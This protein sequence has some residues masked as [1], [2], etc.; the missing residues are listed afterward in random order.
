MTVKVIYKGGKGSG[1]YNHSGRPGEIGGSGPTAIHA[2]NFHKVPKYN[3]VEIDDESDNAMVVL[4]NTEG[5]I[6]YHDNGMQSMNWNKVPGGWMQYHPKLLHNGKY[7]L[8]KALNWPIE[9]ISDNIAAY[10]VRGI[11]TLDEAWS[12]LRAEKV[13]KGGAGS[14]HHGHAGRPGKRGG[15]APDKMTPISDYE[16]TGR[17]TKGGTALSAD[18]F[19]ALDKY[20]ES[21]A[22]ESYKKNVKSYI[23]D[24][25]VVSS[26]NAASHV[27]DVLMNDTA[28]DNPDS[29][30]ILNE[31]VVDK[32]FEHFRDD[33]SRPESSRFSM[34]PSGFGQVYDAGDMGSSVEVKLPTGKTMIVEY[35]NDTDEYVVFY[36]GKRNAFK[37]QAEALVTSM[38][39]ADDVLK[40]ANNSRTVDWQKSDMAIRGIVKDA[41][42][43]NISEKSGIDYPLTNE[44]IGQWAV[45]S[46][47]EDNRSLSL[48]EAA[49]EEFGTPLSN[50]QKSDLRDIHK[51]TDKLTAERDT[52]ER[53]YDEAQAYYNDRATTF[54]KEMPGY[55]VA[56]NINRQWAES[57]PGAPKLGEILTFGDYDIPDELG[58]LTDRATERKFLRTM[59]NETQADFAKRGYKPDDTVRLFRGVG[60]GA[61]KVTIDDV[62][63]VVKYQGNAMESWSLSTKVAIG[64]GSYMIGMDVPVRNIISTARTGYGCLTEGE[65]VV[66]GNYNSTARVI[67]SR[68]EVKDTPKVVYE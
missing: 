22:L 9:H 15:S 21:D 44:L 34:F 23:S 33:A 11:Y 24:N 19:N 45:S 57:H 61:G 4:L 62:G 40:F 28:L 6:T 18:I 3:K 10:Y 5:A 56:S 39:I 30:K 38:N 50:W 29:Y 25:D 66:M 63:N 46:N 27:L 37:T 2:A 47:G 42:V 12:K 26:R 60:E 54:P 64:F 20:Y 41:I 67:F 32:S 55:V 8:S 31:V 65:L 13:Y 7:S 1:N 35:Y 36:D 48:Q 58:S 14:G 52:M 51:R 59:Y 43:T 49:N 17:L 16:V 68:L 53:Y